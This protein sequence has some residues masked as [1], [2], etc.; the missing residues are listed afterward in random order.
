MSSVTRVVVDAVSATLILEDSIINAHH[1]YAA[2]KNY[3]F[4]IT[5]NFYALLPRRHNQGVA[6][7]NTSKAWRMSLSQ[8][9]T[10]R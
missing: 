1:M 3:T 2:V 4:C 7:D 5:T 9:T 6:T 10:Y 8:V